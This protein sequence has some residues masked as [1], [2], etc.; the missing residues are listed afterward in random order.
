[1]IIFGAN[2][3]FLHPTLLKDIAIKI[4][5]AY[6]SYTEYFFIKTIFITVVRKGIRMKKK[7]FSSSIIISALIVCCN[8]TS[9]AQ[10][11]DNYS[12]LEQ[13]TKLI[14]LNILLSSLSGKVSFKHCFNL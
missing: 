14:S 10:P 9:F 7:K 4:K 13:K 11:V 8:S 2:T 12:D 6:I 5:I 1:M 3:T